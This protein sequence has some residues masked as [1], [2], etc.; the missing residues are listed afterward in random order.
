MAKYEIVKIRY[1]AM[2]PLHRG[3]RNSFNFWSCHEF[4]RGTDTFSLVSVEIFVAS[5]FVL[6]SRVD[7]IIKSVLSPN[8]KLFGAYYSS[9]PLGK[10]PG[11]KWQLLYIVSAR[12]PST[13]FHFPDSEPRLLSRLV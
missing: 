3:E 1:I 8:S 2:A 12:V 6:L 4:V 13:V 9:A 10:H 11:F 7:R 5:S